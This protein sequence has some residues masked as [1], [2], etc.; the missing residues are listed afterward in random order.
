MVRVAQRLDD[1][2]AEN[3]RLNAKLEE[4]E[5]RNKRKETKRNAKRNL[6]FFRHSLRRFQGWRINGGEGRRGF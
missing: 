2:E 3:K 4:Q 1:Q 6:D 5:K